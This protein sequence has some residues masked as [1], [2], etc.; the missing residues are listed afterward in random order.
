MR[1]PLSTLAGPCLRS[2]DRKNR[3][4]SASLPRAHDEH[5]SVPS[6]CSS[7]RAFPP[8]PPCDETI[9][10]GLSPRIRSSH[11]SLTSPVA[12]VVIQARHAPTNWPSPEPPSSITSLVARE[13]TSARRTH[14]V[15]RR[16]EL[17][18]RS[19]VRR[20]VRGARIFDASHAGCPPCES[21]LRRK[22]RAVT[23]TTS[24]ASTRSRWLPTGSPLDRSPRS[25]PRDARPIHPKLQL[26]AKFERPPRASRA[27]TCTRK[28]FFDTPDRFWRSS[29]LRQSPCSGC[30][31]IWSAPQQTHRSVSQPMILFRER[32]RSFGYPNS[33]W[34]PFA[35]RPNIWFPKLSGVSRNFSLRSISRP[36]SRRRYHHRKFLC[37]DSILNQSRVE[38]PRRR[39]NS[40]ATQS[41][42]VSKFVRA[43]RDR[44][45]PGFPSSAD[46]WNVRHPLTLVFARER[47]SDSFA[48]SRAVT[49]VRRFAYSYCVRTSTRSFPRAK[50]RAHWLR[51]NGRRIQLATFSR[52][53][54]RIAAA[55]SFFDRCTVARAPPDFRCRSRSLLVQ[56]PARERPGTPSRVRFSRRAPSSAATVSH[57]NKSE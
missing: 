18:R 7:F 28:P 43:I 34:R 11:D 41:V 32:T 26:P 36:K 19:A 15:S 45:R 24:R 48:A 2:R 12:R 53:I 3:S 52:R 55:T 42:R 4:S 46:F 31:R 37:D 54:V 40:G 9:F 5:V 38:F 6:A 51:A 1:S 27:V 17:C 29:R 39:T 10:A 50:A 8:N 33:R 21:C 20:V 22:L 44:Q 25:F 13:M 16:D 57:R 23:R 47:S 14:L 56:S 35:T 30:P 49:C